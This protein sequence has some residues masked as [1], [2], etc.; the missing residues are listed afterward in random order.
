MRVGLFTASWVMVFG[1]DPFTLLK[2]A[3]DHYKIHVTVM[4]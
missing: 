4:A 2:A 3:D 1:P